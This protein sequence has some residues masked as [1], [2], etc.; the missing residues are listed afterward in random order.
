MYLR[1]RNQGRS[2]DFLIR[3]QV[4]GKNTFRSL[5][6]A[7]KVSLREARE[8]AKTYVASPIV[9]KMTFEQSIKEVYPIVCAKKCWK[10]KRDPKKFLSYI[11]KYLYPSLGTKE[12]NRITV[13]DVVEVINPLWISKPEF[14][15]KILGVL[16]FLFKQLIVLGYTNTNP[17]KFKDGLDLF[18]PAKSKVYTVVHY[19]TLSAEDLQK[20]IPKLLKLNRCRTY[21]CV[22]CALTAL[23]KNEVL[24]LKWEYIR[25]DK[26]LGKYFNIPAIYRKGNYTEDHRVPITSEMEYILSRLPRRNE[27]IFPGREGPVISNNFSG[28][29]SK[30]NTTLHGFRSTFR[31]WAATNKLDFIVC[32]AVLSHVIGS[33]VTRS[34]LR[35]DF[36]N[37]RREVL[38]KWNQ[39]L[40]KYVE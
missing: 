23:R 34:Y 30:F 10:D 35:T 4:E 13:K 21:F 18:L 27:Y 2:R 32:E 40:F 29:L 3:V 36:F 5:G 37:E 31:D 8:K 38:N 1:V 11:T 15:S 16:H 24:N 6:S 19:R 26:K 33:T 20:L 22:L 7:K 14:T 25:E 28:F 12:V 39:Y 9:K 17:F